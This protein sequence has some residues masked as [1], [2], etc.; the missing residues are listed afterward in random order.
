MDLYTLCA[1][2]FGLIS[3]AA[4]TSCSS[5]S[6]DDDL[7][8]NPRFSPAK[9]LMIRQQTKV[10]SS[11]VKKIITLA[12]DCDKEFN[13]ANANVLEIREYDDAGKVLTEEELYFNGIRKKKVEFFYDQAGN[14]THQHLYND[15]NTLLQ[16]TYFN[17]LG[18]DTLTANYQKDGSLRNSI[19]KFLEYSPGGF[20]K[21]IQEIDDMGRTHSIV[22]FT[23]SDTLLIEEELA[24]FNPLSGNP[25]GTELIKYNDRGD[26]AYMSSST[27]STID[28]EVTMGY[29]YNEFGKI[30]NARLFNK[31]GLLI[32]E[33]NNSFYSGGTV[34]TITDTYFDPA[35][36]KAYQVY[37]EYYLEDGNLQST[38][39]KD[40]NG[41]TLRSSEFTYNE[42]GLLVE[43]VEYDPGQVPDYLCTR[44]IYEF[45]D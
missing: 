14:L 28:E 27:G 33:K 13:N 38:F 40:S 15:D 31:D 25:I 29:E 10:A 41:L 23:F 26:R 36:G 43:T 16:K 39:L 1:R 17:K 19:Q 18:F 42:K 9:K 3:L 12:Y 8:I 4:F 35:D 45:F 22:S 24:T 7:I 30:E 6:S 2:I 37:E 5:G 20:V 44:L 11:A 21:S 34:K 32:R